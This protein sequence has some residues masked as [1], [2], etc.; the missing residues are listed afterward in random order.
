MSF[1]AKF[2][3]S[4]SLCQKIRKIKM[5]PSL[6]HCMFVT[7]DGPLFVIMY[8]SDIRNFEILNSI[9]VSTMGNFFSVIFHF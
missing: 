5:S 2:E 4:S 3:F 8:R 1:E 6:D 9:D 7:T